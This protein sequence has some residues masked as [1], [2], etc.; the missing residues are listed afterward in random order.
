MSLT[1]SEYAAARERFGKSRVELPGADLELFEVAEIERRQAEYAKHP[2]WRPHWLAIGVDHFVGD[3]L[4]LNVK[5]AALP[6]LTWMA[7]IDPDAWMVAVDPAAFFASLERALGAGENPA[8][9]LEA[10]DELNDGAV[11]LDFWASVLDQDL[12]V[13]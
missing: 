1:P 2:N 10:I 11:D 8:K 5:D 9:A 6:V 13:E 7:D 4:F 3:A 12:P